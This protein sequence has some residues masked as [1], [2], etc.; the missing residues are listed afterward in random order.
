[1]RDHLAEC[2]PC[3]AELSAEELIK[4]LVRRSCIE[5]A[6]EALRLRIFARLSVTTIDS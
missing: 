5:R 2:S 4:A 3:L 6:P 1:M